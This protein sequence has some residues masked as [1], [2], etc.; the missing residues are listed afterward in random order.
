MGGIRRFGQVTTTEPLSAG[1]YFKWPFIEEADILQVSLDT[2]RIDDLVVY[3]VD[4]QPVTIS[5]SMSYR[6]PRPAV[7]RLMYEVGRAG[8]VDIAENIRPILSDRIARIFARTNTTK[9]SEQR[10][11]IGNEIKKS[12]Q[13]SLGEVFGLEV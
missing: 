7:F 10:E 6:I 3:T 13:Q 2:F 5:V 9:I 1:L 4:N 8:S 11:Q 12:V